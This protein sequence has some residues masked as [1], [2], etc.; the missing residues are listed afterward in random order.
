MENSHTLVAIRGVQAGREFYTAMLPLRVIPKLF[1]FDEPDLP[2]DL[3][4]QRTLNKARVPE[5]ARYL[6]KNPRG[7]VLPALT[8]SAD[9]NVRFEP[10]A[11]AGPTKN[12]GRL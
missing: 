11:E 5:I 6:T 12:I 2:A 4:A 3:R 8:A 7:Y 10:L 1:Q 9:G